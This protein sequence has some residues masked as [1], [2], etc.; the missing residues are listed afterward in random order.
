MS[1][2]NQEV[3]ELQEAP[4]VLDFLKNEAQ[5]LGVKHHPKI[6]EAKLREKIQV[7]KEAQEKEAKKAEKETLKSPVQGR[8]KWTKRDLQRSMLQMVR[9]RVS[10]LNPHYKGLKGQAFSTSNG[11]TG[12]VKKY[13]PF[14]SPHGWHVPKVLIDELKKK[15]HQTFREITTPTGKKIKRGV[16]VPSFAIQE[17]PPLTAEEWKKIMQ[18]LRATSPTEDY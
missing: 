1:D 7:F 9:V 17:L 16:K 12:T 11:I 2:E 14:D 13:V 18:Q 10:C 3:E 15:K 5:A 6:G 8:A 4:T